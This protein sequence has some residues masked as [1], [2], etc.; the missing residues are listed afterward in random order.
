[1]NEPSRRA[2]EF[3]E[4]V[5]RPEDGLFPFSTS[6]ANGELHS[7]YDNPLARR[8]SLI[9]LLGLVEALT[10]G[11]RQPFLDDLDQVVERFLV[12]HGGNVSNWGDRGLLLALLARADLDRRQSERLL[13]EARFIRQGRSRLSVQDLSWLLW[14]VTENSHRIPR[15]TELARSLYDGLTERYVSAGAALPCHSLSRHRRRIVSFGAVVYYLHA[16]NR[17]GRSFDDEDAITRFQTVAARLIALQL[18]NGGWPWLL[19]VDEGVSL[20]AYPLYSVHQLSMSML[21]LLP[22][23]ELGVPGATESVERSF[24]WVRG[25]NELGIPLVVED[26]RF[27]YRSIERKERWSRGRRYTRSMIRALGPRT[28]RPE[29]QPEVRLNPESRSYEWGWLLWVW[30]QQPYA[31]AL[32]AQPGP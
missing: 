26:G 22:A 23:G 27:I 13:E 16:L 3:L 25:S 29:S 20:D 28:A 9:S 15:A 10:N 7:S 2:L 32:S 30:S 24:V 8:Y 4:R 12:A 5:V 1:M 18:P 31:P 21:F 19:D 11:A 14:G 6:F 17:F